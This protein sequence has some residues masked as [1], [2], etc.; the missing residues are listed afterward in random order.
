DCRLDHRFFTAALLAS[1][2]RVLAFGVPGGILPIG[3]LAGRPIRMMRP[4]IV[5]APRRRG[6]TGSG[7]AAIL[8]QPVADLPEGIA[9][10]GRKRLVDGRMAMLGEAD[11]LVRRPAILLRDN[12]KD[13]WLAV[14][15]IGLR[16]RRG[17]GL[18][19]DRVVFRMCAVGGRR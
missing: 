17:P 16:S 13:G 8:L 19:A 10:A 4:I 3:A 9:L 5:G 1:R 2:S 11:H 15:R 12:G 18:P 14:E 7:N 6:R